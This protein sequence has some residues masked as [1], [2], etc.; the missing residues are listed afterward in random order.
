MIKNTCPWQKKIICTDKTLSFLPYLFHNSSWW[1]IFSYYDKNPFQVLEKNYSKLKIS[2][3]I[4]LSEALEV[5][6][7]LINI[8]ERRLFCKYACIIDVITLILFLSVSISTLTTG[9]LNKISSML[10]ILIVV[11]NLALLFLILYLNIFLK[12]IYFNKCM[13]AIERY[14]FSINCEMYIQNS[15]EWFVD[16]QQNLYT[17]F[18][19]IR[20]YNLKS[21]EKEFGLI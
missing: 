8:P 9:A 14:F 6:N 15:R 21:L 3:L 4:D 10:F 11:L 18:I 20:Y 7:P 19:G 13:I 16:K 2:P 5:L 17:G 1:N 12:T